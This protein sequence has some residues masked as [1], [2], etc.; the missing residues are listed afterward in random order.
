[1]D[2]DPITL[3]DVDDVRSGAGHNA[4]SLVTRN[5]RRGGLYRP[6]AVRRVSVGTAQT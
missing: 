3:F 5:E 6:V 2:R 1:M 4:H